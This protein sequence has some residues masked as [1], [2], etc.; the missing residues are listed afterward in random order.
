LLTLFNRIE[1][2]VFGLPFFVFAMLALD[3]LVVLL[4]LVAYQVTGGLGSCDES[5]AG[6]IAKRRSA[7]PTDVG[8]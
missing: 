5:S 2:F 1:P 4:L 6:P 3:L 7:N 8:S